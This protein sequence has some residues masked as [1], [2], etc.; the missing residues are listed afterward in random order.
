M[1]TTLFKVAGMTCG[2]CVARVTNALRLVHGVGNVNVSLA[3]AAA[4]VEFDHQLTTL[5]QLQA[6]VR[7]AGY[8][9][10]AVQTATQKP[11]GGC[12]CH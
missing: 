10:D 11:K 8:G 5:E 1:Q 12:C 4:T 2:S 7:H 3:G 6:A 9:I